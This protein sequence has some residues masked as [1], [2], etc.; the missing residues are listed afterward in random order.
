MKQMLRFQVSLFGPTAIATPK[1]SAFKHF[2][3][4]HSRGAYS[5]WFECPAAEDTIA[6]EHRILKI[7]GTGV[8]YH[9][10]YLGSAQMPDGSTM[11]HLIEVMS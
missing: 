2:D 11:F 9:G 7:V 6:D 1:G 4:Q 8:A 10:K 5:A 3:Y